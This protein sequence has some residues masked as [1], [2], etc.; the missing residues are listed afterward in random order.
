[1]E[2]IET[3][4]QSVDEAK[5]LLIDRLGVDEAEAEF[6]ILEEPKPGLFGR[7]KGQARVRARVLPQDHRP[8]RQ[9][10][11]KD[12]ASGRPAEGTAKGDRPSGDRGAARNDPDDRAGRTPVGK[13][14]TPAKDDPG[15]RGPRLESAVAK[16]ATEEFLSA[17]VGHFGLTAGVDV[18]VDDAGDLAATVSGERLGALIGP[19]GGIVTAVEELARTRLQHVA[20]G[21]STPRLRVD[22]GG[23]RSSRRGDLDT[24]VDE[25]IGKVRATGVPHMIDIVLS[26]ERKV[27]HDRVAASAP[28]LTTRSEGEEPDRRVVIS[29]AN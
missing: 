10:R 2:W 19:R 15:E 28:D 29:P 11:R 12:S 26:G 17:L 16:S 5:E 14:S 13:V 21:G 20:L 6:E 4:G 3:T 27:V 7:T 22:I 24:F 23:Y 9:R 18:E 25:V 1:M 8:E